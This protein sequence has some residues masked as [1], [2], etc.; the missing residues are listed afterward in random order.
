MKI[1]RLLVFDA[2]PVI[3]DE[4]T[5]AQSTFP[6]L[7][8]EK[9]AAS[10]GSI[11]SFLESTYGAR[12]IRAVETIKAVAADRFASKHLKV[13]V[14][15]PLLSVDRVAFTYDDKPVEWRQGRCL[16]EGYSYLNELA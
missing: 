8:M 9:L 13:S 2:K 4:I 3:L 10:Q 16:T 14:G 12:M 7:T 5:L 6:A 11:Y 15:T 1:S